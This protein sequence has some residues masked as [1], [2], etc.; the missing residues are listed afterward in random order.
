LSYYSFDAATSNISRPG[1]E[2]VSRRRIKGRPMRGHAQFDKGSLN[3]Y[4]IDP[5]SSIKA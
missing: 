4:V 3:K 1:Q 5:H 2:E